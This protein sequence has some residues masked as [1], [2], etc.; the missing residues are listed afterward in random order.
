MSGSI[1]ILFVATHLPVPANNGQAI[2]SLSIIQAL[3]SSGHEL[4]FVSFVNG[5]RPEELQPL[6]S[7]CRSIDL[8]ERQMTNLTQG[9]DY[10]RRMGSLLAIKSFSVERY[11]SE[12]MRKLIQEKLQAESYDLIICEGIYSLINIPENE[13]PIALDCH[14]IE[15][16]ILKRYAELERNFLKRH[17]AQ[18]ESRLIRMAE[19]RSCHQVSLA[20]VCSQIDLNIL[21]QFR[22]DLPVFI[23]PNVVDTDLVRPV[24]PASLGTTEPVLLFQGGMDWYPNR[25]AVDFFARLILP[26]VREE[27]PDVRFIIAGRNPPTSF[28]KQFRS[29]PMIEFTGTVPD[30]RPYLA[31]ATIVIVPLRVGGGTRI[32]ILEACAAGKPVVSTSVGAEGLNLEP[33]KEITLADGP[34]EFAQA[35]LM[36]LKDQVRSEAFAKASRKAV[37]ERYSHQTLRESLRVLIANATSSVKV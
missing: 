31:C 12:A 21:R 22:S 6:S 37:V 16:I 24:E 28:I 26:R 32:K 3:E 9:T 5:R 8:L 11:R 35:V 4:S 20:M 19:R 29:D 2:R 1:K 7:F 23:V 34:I 30:M 27:V 36:L 14:N 13:V 18:I 17:Y 15:Y 10:L 25:D 33:G